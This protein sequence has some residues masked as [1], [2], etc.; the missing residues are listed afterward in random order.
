MRTKF[1][2][3]DPGLNRLGGHNYTLAMTFSDAAHAMGHDVLWLCHKKF[4][5]ELVP[6]YIRA[7]RVFPLSYPTFPKW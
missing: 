6:S 5:S 4:P 7:E 2:I 1:V 3:I